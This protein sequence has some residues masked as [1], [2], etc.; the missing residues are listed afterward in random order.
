MSESYQ[1]EPLISGQDLRCTDIGERMW[2]HLGA[3]ARRL[4]NTQLRNT[5]LQ[6][7]RG[8]EDGKIY[9]LK[10]IWVQQDPRPE[11]QEYNRETHIMMCLTKLVVFNEP[12]E[13]LPDEWVRRFALLVDKLAE[14]EKIDYGVLGGPIF[15]PL[16]Q[17]EGKHRIMIALYVFSDYEKEELN[18]WLG[19]PAFVDEGGLGD[20]DWT[21]LPE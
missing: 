14:A 2:P 9:Q 11:G 4:I 6:F 21:N 1:G 15:M 3:K 8:K 19:N 7:D 12:V 16:V 5:V 13:D 20:E 17:I 18:E 10:P